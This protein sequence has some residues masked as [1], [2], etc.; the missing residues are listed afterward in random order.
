MAAPPPLSSPLATHRA[1]APVSS[2]ALER[3]PHLGPARG[4]G[5]GTVC[6]GGEMLGQWVGPRPSCTQQKRDCSPCPKPVGLRLQCAPE[7]PGWCVK[8]QIARCSSIEWGLRICVSRVLVSRVPQGHPCCGTRGGTPLHFAKHCPEVS[9]LGYVY[10]RVT[11]MP[12]L[13]PPSPA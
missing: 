8:A 11:R 12:P 3:L 2:L 6:P 5:A 1:S 13:L 10:R 9:Y 7:V 4:H